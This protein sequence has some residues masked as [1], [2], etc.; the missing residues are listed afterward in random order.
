[1]SK[2]KQSEEAYNTLLAR[3]RQARPESSGQSEDRLKLPAPQT[4]VS[5]KKTFWL[6][7][8]EFPNLLRRDPIDYLNY[9]RSQLAINASIENGRAIFMGRPDK[10]SFAALVQRYVKERVICP[11]CGSPDTRL[12]KNKQVLTLLCEACGARSAAK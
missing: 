1:M 3:I 5:G 7:F 11:V 4:M 2:Q 9:F 12:E 6:N 8:M 10:Q